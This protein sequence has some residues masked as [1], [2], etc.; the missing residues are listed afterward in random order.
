[1]QCLPGTISLEKH[2]PPLLLCCGHSQ[3]D[4]DWQDDRNPLALCWLAVWAVYLDIYISVPSGVPRFYET[5]QSICYG[6]HAWGQRRGHV[7]INRSSEPL[8]IL[9]L[10]DLYGWLNYIFID[11]LANNKS[12]KSKETERNLSDSVYLLSSVFSQ[13]NIFLNYSLNGLL[14]PDLP[15]KQA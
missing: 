5:G 14:L 11:S 8:L 10:T 9:S 3:T 13:E 6:G 7:N 2:S 12:R 4:N 15:S 1:M